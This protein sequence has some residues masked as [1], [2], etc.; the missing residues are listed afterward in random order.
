M[1]AV[2]TSG[3]T[4]FPDTDGDDQILPRRLSTHFVT[5]GL[6]HVNAMFNFD[7]RPTMFDDVMECVKY[8]KVLFFKP[9]HLELNQCEAMIIERD[10]EGSLAIG[11]EDGHTRFAET[12]TID[13]IE[14]DN[15]VFRF[16]Y[17]GNAGRPHVVQIAPFM[18]EGVMSDDEE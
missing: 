11:Y 14:M 15:G 18:V 17:S 8:A 2:A 3:V 1:G 9:M 10:S 7:G 4:D 13:S 6:Y 5:G 12:T 16:I